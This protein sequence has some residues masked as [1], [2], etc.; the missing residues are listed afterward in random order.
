VSSLCSIDAENLQQIANAPV[1][2]AATGELV[3]ALQ[4]RIHPTS[5]RLA[6][7]PIATIRRK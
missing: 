5:S 4:D 3:G 1:A 6:A 2:C 7:K